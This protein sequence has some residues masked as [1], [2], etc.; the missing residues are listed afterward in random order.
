MNVGEFIGCI[1][2]MV[3]ATLILI[4]SIVVIVSIIVDSKKQ[5]EKVD[6]DDVAAVSVISLAGT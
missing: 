5:K 2:L 1:M 4:G 3:L 6:P